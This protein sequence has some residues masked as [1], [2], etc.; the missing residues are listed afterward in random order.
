MT[1][2]QRERWLMDFIRMFRQGGLSGELTV[3][4]RDGVPVECVPAPRYKPP[5]P[6]RRAGESG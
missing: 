1:E 2:S 3:R 6:G 4:F 5:E